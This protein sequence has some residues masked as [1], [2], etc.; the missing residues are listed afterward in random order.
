M[1]GTAKPRLSRRRRALRLVSGVLDPRAWAH[2]FKLVNYYNYSHVA[3]LRKV[4][5]GPGAA[6]SPNAVFS[7]PERI[8][9]GRGLHLGARCHLWAG[10]SHGRIVIGD[11]VLFGPE[12]MVTAANYRFNDGSP[13]T[14]QK[15]D[16]ADVVIGNDVWLATRVTVLPG[17]RIGDGAIIGAG[18]VVTGDIPAHAIAVGVPARVVGARTPFDRPA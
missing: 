18:A 15:M 6:I 12:V 11:D 3:P 9:A 10:P 14:A 2:L 4:T 5:L 8:S 17:A 16:E 1:T 7:N 13:V